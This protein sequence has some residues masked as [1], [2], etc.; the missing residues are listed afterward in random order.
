MKLTVPTSSPWKRVLKRG[1]LVAAAN[2]EVTLIQATTD[3]LYKLLL[4]T[5]VF[6][7]VF[8]VG[9]VLGSAPAD[10]MGLE[11]REM[12]ATIITSLVSHPAVL[13]AF[14][15]ALG[16]MGAGGG[17]FVVLV[18]GG[19]V[20]VLLDGDRAAGDIETPPLDT[21]A[22]ARAGRFT[23][24]SFAT[25]CRR[26]LGRYMWL[27][28]WLGV[29]YLVSAVAYLIVIYQA[30]Y[31]GEWSG[32]ALLGA[33]TFFIAW[34]TAINFGYLLMQLVMAADDCGIAVAW[35][36]V[37]GF[38]SRQRRHVL[39]VFGIVFLLVVAATGASV[40]ATG[41]LGLI[42]F[43]PFVGLAVLP[44]Q[45]V[46]WIF[47]SIVFQYLSLTAIGAYLRLYRQHCDEIGRPV[48]AG[49]PA[50]VPASMDAVQT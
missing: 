21:A 26:L 7:G 11:W 28:V 30:G 45:L 44:L 40:V 34:V 31:R 37:I 36:R 42:A 16:V 3:S 35:P 18:K 38:V 33:T 46:A 50:A 2:W 47:R 13:A 5:P 9:L 27:G 14:V 15:A 49:D 4:A 1:A 23:V 24:E 19:A 32:L 25:G 20:T 10:L 41:A 48:L 6:G 43:V 22:V 8:L 17:I 29:V 39:R 12:A